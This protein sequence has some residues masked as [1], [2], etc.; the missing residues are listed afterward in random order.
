MPYDAAVQTG[1]APGARRRAQIQ[2]VLMN[3]E[4][5][6]PHRPDGEPQDYRECT[7]SLPEILH[8]DNP[9]L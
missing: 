4:T 5:V 6:R 9:N 1:F 2:G 3:M 8:I 7:L